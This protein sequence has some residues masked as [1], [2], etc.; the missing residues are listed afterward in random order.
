MLELKTVATPEA[1]GLD[2]RMGLLGQP[3]T[4]PATY[5]YDDQGSQ[6]F[7]QIC[8]LP[9]YYPTRT[10]AAILATLAPQLPGLTGTATLIELGS[11]SSTKTRL[12]LDAYTQAGSTHYVPIDVSRG[13]LQHS[14]Q[15]LLATYANLTVTGLVGD[16]TAALQHLPPAQRRLVL[17]L[18]S[19]LGNLDAAECTRFLATI[20]LALTRGDY[21]LVGIDLHKDQHIL[22]AAYNDQAGVTAAFNRNVLTHLNTRFGCTFQP[23]RFE[24]WAFYNTDMQQIEMHL[25]STCDQVVDL[26]S[27]EAHIELLTGETIRTEISRKFDLATFI[28]RLADQGLPV[29]RTWHDKRSW[30]A[31]LLCQ[32]V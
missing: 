18:G 22:E 25:R 20:R 28:P 5:F 30:F 26:G 14:A 7:E 27:L 8:T 31:V 1:A 21:F 15:A 13:I 9:E 32:A 16:Y 4:L 6:L 19:T 12:L 2:V 10:E 24:H 3:K 17:F 23:E 11:G 29:R